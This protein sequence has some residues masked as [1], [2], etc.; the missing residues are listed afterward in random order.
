MAGRGAARPRNRPAG[1]GKAEEPDLLEGVQ[2][3]NR[4]NQG[5]QSQKLQKT[6]ERGGGMGGVGGGMW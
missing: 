3:T 1:A 5:K 6:Y 2:E 4:G